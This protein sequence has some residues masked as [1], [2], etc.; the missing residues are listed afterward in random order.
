MTFSSEPEVCRD[1]RGCESCDLELE[2][3]VVALTR[4]NARKT[5]PQNTRA[6]RVVLDH[7]PCELSLLFGGRNLLE[8]PS[9]RFLVPFRMVRPCKGAMCTCAKLCK[10][11]PWKTCIPCQQL[12]TCQKHVRN[13]TK[14]HVRN[15]TK[16]CQKLYQK[17]KRHVRSMSDTPAC[18]KPAR[19][20]LGGFTALFPWLPG[21]LHLLRLLHLP[22]LPGILLRPRLG[23]RV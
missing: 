23:F 18:Q 9:P 4:E 5:P 6:N 8:S 12:E 1:C 15:S 21:F 20:T 14:Q 3:T 19:L 11:P 2:P 7:A 22:G 10:H 13:S 17:K 16:T